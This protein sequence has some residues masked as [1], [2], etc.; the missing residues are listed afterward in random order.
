LGGV[1]KLVAVCDGGEWVPA[2]KISESP[3]KTPNPGHK[4][5]WRVYD[6]RSKATADLLSLDDEDP[7]EMEQIVLRHP[8]DHT[9]Y[10]LLHQDDIAEI[11]P[12]LVDVVRDG[13]V[14]C[15]LPPIEGIRQR[16]EADMDRLDPGVKRLLNPHIY[17][18]S[19]T[20]RLWD[21]KHELIDSA[22]AESQ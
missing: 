2:I 7:R 8:V 10:R 4:R 22:K 11:E 15:D 16:R 12:L 6:R 18:V 19:L 1:Y 17:H 20:Q 14:V 5:V 13:A 3:D 9:K 21:L